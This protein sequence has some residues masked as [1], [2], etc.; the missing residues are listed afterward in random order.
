MKEKDIQPLFGKL[1]T[2]I[3]A[4]ELKLCKSNS[5]RWDAVK[6]HQLE[7]LYNVKHNG[8]YYKI[9][10]APFIPNRMTFTKPKPFDCFFMKSNAY[11]VICFYIPNKQKTFYY[12]D[13]DDY[14]KNI[15]QNGK[16]SFTEEEAK[17][18]SCIVMP[19][20]AQN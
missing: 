18:M 16:K 8:L 15:E 14:H 9:N 6:P 17:S 19:C 1:N 11:V 5:I 13:I 3:G 2:E 4:F 12:I 20:K 7:A 10:D